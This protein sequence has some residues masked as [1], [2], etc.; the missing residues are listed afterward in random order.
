MEAIGRLAGGIAHDFN[1]I[2]TAILGYSE[3]IA[4]NAGDNTVLKHDI[5]QIHAGGL[6]AAALTQQLLTFSR[7]QVTL[8]KPLSVNK[9]IRAMEHMLQRL[10]G[11]HIRLDTRLNDH[12]DRV[13]ADPHQLEQVIMNLVINARDAVGDGGLILIET[14][15]VHLD[16]LFAQQKTHHR[17]GHLHPH[18]DQ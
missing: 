12:L 14:S 15:Q 17:A 9:V 7:K 10:I 5:E 11:E 13:Q 3:M 16:G 6:R 1:N 18:R 2:M 8:A 4:R